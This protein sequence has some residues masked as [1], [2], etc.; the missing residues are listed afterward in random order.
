M[1][2]S[3]DGQSAVKESTHYAHGLVYSDRPL[4]G[5][6]EFEVMLTGHGN[7]WSGNFKLGLVQYSAGEPLDKDNIPRYSPEGENCCVWCADKV[8]DHIHGRIEKK[9]GHL[10]LDELREGDRLGLQ[11]TKDGVLSFFVNDEHQGVAVVGVHKDGYDLYALV[12]HYGQA[13]S[14]VIS[15]AS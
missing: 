10:T 1:F 2:I 12:D 14:T 9:Y 13:K 4:R 5:T 6:C 3:E 15:K 11:V 8:H 7:S